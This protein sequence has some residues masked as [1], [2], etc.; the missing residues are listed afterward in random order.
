MRRC[1]VGKDTLRLFFIGAKQSTSCG[2]LTED[3]QTE[4]KKGPRL[5]RR[6]LGFAW[7]DRRR[8][9]YAICQFIRV[10]TTTF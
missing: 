1:V 7:L 10:K 2:S 3:L 9:S 6:W 5:I 4:S 8:V